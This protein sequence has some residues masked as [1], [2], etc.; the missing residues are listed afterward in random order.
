MPRL[1]VLLQM[2]RARLLIRLLRLPALSPCAL[3]RT[4]C[5]KASSLFSASITTVTT[6]TATTT[7]SSSSSTAKFA[8]RF[9]CVGSLLNIERE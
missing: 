8:C 6:A 4:L 3:L 1:Q 5:G 7:T 9:G 2:I